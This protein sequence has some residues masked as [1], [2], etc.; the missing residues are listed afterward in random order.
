MKRYF[1]GDPVDLRFQIRRVGSV[2]V[3]LQVLDLTNPK[4]IEVLR[5]R[6]S[7]LIHDVRTVVQVVAAWASS[8]E[9]KGLL[10]PSAA[11]S[12]ARTLVV[13]SS[14]LDAIT[15]IQS[16][17]MTCDNV[18]ELGVTGAGFLSL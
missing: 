8:Q 7:D 16:R 6:P 5:L 4:V 1:L 12:G 11:L 3:D 10:L 14:G 13:F 17:F 9:Y 15:E 2:H 18:L